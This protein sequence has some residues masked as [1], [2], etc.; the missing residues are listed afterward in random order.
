MQAMIG[1]YVSD[2]AETTLK[3]VLTPKG[4]EIHQR[5][6]TVYPL[7]P[8]YTDGFECELGSIRFVRDTS[9]HAIGM[10]LSDSRMWD[11]RLKK[12]EAR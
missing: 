1:D 4:L 11:L 3:V 5:P 2:E 12:M 8:T 9:G 7:K 6:D 10:S